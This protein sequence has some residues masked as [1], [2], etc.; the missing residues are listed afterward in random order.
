M[1]RPEFH[2]YD[3]LQGDQRPPINFSIPVLSNQD[4]NGSNRLSISQKSFS[5]FVP[6]SAVHTD[7]FPRHTQDTFMGPHPTNSLDPRV[8]P[9]SP[10]NAVSYSQFTPNQQPT[11]QFF[12]QPTSRLPPASSFHLTK[13]SPTSF[14]P[15]D[16][17]ISRNTS[18]SSP[19]II[20]PQPSADTTS[21]LLWGDLEPWMDEEY[22]KQVGMIMHWDTISIK[23]PK[24]PA[25]ST[26]G[27]QANNKGYCY[28]TFSNSAK[29]A[30]AVSQIIHSPNPMIMP[31]STKPFS[32]TWA[33]SVPVTPPP[34]ATAPAYVPP[35]PYP[36]QQPHQFTKE[37]SIF[38]G[39]LAPEVSN[40][41]LV[42]VFRNPVL[43]LR[44]DREPRFIRPFLSCKSAKIMLD[45]VTGVSR[46]YGFVR[47]VYSFALCEVISLKSIC[48]P[49]NRFTEEADQ[50]RALI[51]MHGLYCLSRPS[52]C[53]PIYS[54]RQIP[55]MNC[56]R[57]AYLPRNGEIQVTHAASG[58]SGTNDPKRVN[59][60]RWP[61]P[62]ATFS[63]FVHCLR[64]TPFWSI[65]PCE[66]RLKLFPFNSKLLFELY[67]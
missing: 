20:S 24:P 9:H 31:N 55:V 62:K 16:T 45:P 22:A 18:Q 28:L 14:L 27:P 58:P 17:Y 37:Y 3:L 23:V 4:R 41:D 49:T 10:V 46:G 19:S 39:D 66:H 50:Q 42:A 21:T 6:R 2:D 56:G 7:L 67:A 32:L 63:P 48:A 52:K 13:A 26:N 35:N 61:K 15:S 64:A 11:P 34:P 44:N 38:V 51:E 53:F 30:A 1:S 40:S 8:L 25:D 33:T 43:G 60:D 57:S 36:T 12:T 47:L 59:P 65:W 54:A 5:P 29:A